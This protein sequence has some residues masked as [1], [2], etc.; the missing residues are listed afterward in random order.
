VTDPGIARDGKVTDTNVSTTVREPPF[1][2]MISYP[3]PVETGRRFGNL[4]LP[5]T[6]ERADANRLAAFVQTLVVS[7]D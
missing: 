7:R 3:F 6:L 2:P 5:Q 1:N 4:L